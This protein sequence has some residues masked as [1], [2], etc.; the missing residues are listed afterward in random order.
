M[1]LP[2][3][4]QKPLQNTIRPASITELLSWDVTITFSECWY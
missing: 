2:V 4:E 3:R 1:I